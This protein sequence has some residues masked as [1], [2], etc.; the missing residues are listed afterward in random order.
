MVSA[1]EW[2]VNFWLVLRCDFP[3]AC[4]FRRG[5]VQRPALDG[6][7]GLQRP[8]DEEDPPVAKAP[9]RHHGFAVRIPGVGDPPHDAFAG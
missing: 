1:K 7:V 3:H 2:T 5:G 9:G 8:V 6:R 4:G